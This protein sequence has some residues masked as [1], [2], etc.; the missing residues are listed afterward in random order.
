VDGFKSIVKKRTAGQTI[1]MVHYDCCSRSL[2]TAGLFC[3]G[4]LNAFSISLSL[5]WIS[6]GSSSG[7]WS[8]VLFLELSESWSAKFVVKGF[9]VFAL[10]FV[11]TLGHNYLLNIAT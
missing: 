10:L 4:Y 2:E 7:F 5:C 9:M 11:Y 8:S 1:Q 3:V 6:L